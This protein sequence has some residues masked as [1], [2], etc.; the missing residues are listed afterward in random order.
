[1]GSPVRQMTS[2]FPV[3]PTLS[4]ISS[5]I[6]TLSISARMTITPLFWFSLAIHNS[7]IIV[8]IFDDHPRISTW[9][10]SI[11]NERPFRSSSI[12]SRIPL[13]IK[14]IKV[15]IIT[16]PTKVVTIMKSLNGQFSA[17]PNT[18]GSST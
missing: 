4:L 7:E 11:T 12:F 3:L 17:A 9:S 1:M 6:S 13:E 5:S 14:P 16:R 2:V 8:K 10:S 15:E 18:P